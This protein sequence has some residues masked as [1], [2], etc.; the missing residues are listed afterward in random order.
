MKRYTCGNGDGMFEDKDGLW[1]NIFDHDEQ[2]K[3]L[4][5][6]NE[7]LI[8]E[9]RKPD[10]VTMPLG[11]YADKLKTIDKQEQQIKIHNKKV[12]AQEAELMKGPRR[13]CRKLTDADYERFYE[14][15]KQALKK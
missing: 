15:F 6:A 12:E 5:E 1:V 8:N 4:E 13:Y 11:V 2:I 14:T 7:E 10:T 9:A 3:A